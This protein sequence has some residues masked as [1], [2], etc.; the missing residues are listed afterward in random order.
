LLLFFLLS[1]SLSSKTGIYRRLL[2]DTSEAK[3]KKKIDTEKRDFVTFS[4]DE[5]NAVFMEDDPVKLYE[6]RDIAKKFIANPE[7]SDYLPEKKEVEIPE[8]GLISVTPHAVINFEISREAAYQTYISVLG[9]LTA[10]YDDL[11]NTLANEQFDKSF[12]R[13]TETQQ[14]AIRE[15]YP[16]R[17]SEKELPG[18]EAQDE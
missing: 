1:G 8:L 6:I 12:E 9:E 5:T 7:N 14:A 18:K 10:A 2:P 4:I 3:L 13:L 15:A 11:R 17:I 16:L